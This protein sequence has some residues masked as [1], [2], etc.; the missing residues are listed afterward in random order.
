LL[1]IF[2]DIRILIYVT[3]ASANEGFGV[4]VF[5][6]SEANVLAMLLFPHFISKICFQIILNKNYFFLGKMVRKYIKKAL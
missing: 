4:N 3:F 1:D 6:N 5:D 2:N